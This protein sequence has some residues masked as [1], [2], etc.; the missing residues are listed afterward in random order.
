MIFSHID[1]DT[2]NAPY[3]EGVKKALAY[4]KSHD[5]TQMEPGRYDIEGDDIFALVQEV[6][7]FKLGENRPETHTNYLDVQYLASGME[8]LGFA[9]V[10]NGHEV[11]EALPDKDVTFYKSVA[12]ENFVVS[13]PGCFCVF[14]PEDIHRP[15]VAVNDEPLKIR[16]VV[17][18]VKVGI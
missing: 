7:T 8:R 17:V 18:K 16:K 2:T 1:F 5:F 12:N 15:S 10:T 9:P 4:L 13:T 11:D 3:S 6:T 14:Y